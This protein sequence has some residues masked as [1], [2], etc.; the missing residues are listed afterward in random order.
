LQ[1]SSETLI[2]VLHAN[3]GSVK[4]APVE[5]SEDFLR[6]DTAE[7][8]SSLASLRLFFV[9]MRTRSNSAGTARGLSLDDPL[10]TLAH[11]T[12]TSEK[13][14]EVVLLR[15][16]SLSPLEI[17]RSCEPLSRKSIENGRSR[18]F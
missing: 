7:M 16:A 2:A 4:V 1:F 10:E 5:I 11:L 9:E 8:A 12:Q 6:D 14:R 13:L 18:S 3:S 15:S 17:G